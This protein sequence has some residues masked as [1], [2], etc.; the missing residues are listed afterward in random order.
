MK[1]LAVSEIRS[2]MQNLE[3]TKIKEMKQVLRHEGILGVEVKIH[4]FCNSNKT[5]A[6]GRLHMLAALIS[7]KRQLEYTLS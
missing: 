5:Q 6:T 7:S 2:F 4:V 1:E 3:C